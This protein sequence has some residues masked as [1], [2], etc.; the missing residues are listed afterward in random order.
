[1]RLRSAIFAVLLFFPA[2][3]GAQLSENDNGTQGMPGMN[4]G[5]MQGMQMGGDGL[6]TMHPES[7]LQ[8]IVRHGTSG[9]SAEP[10]STPV[11]M[12]MT[13]KGV[14]MLMFHANAF[15]IDEQQS[16]PRGGNKFFSTNWFMGMAQRPLGPGVF[17]A[18]AMSSL[19]PATVTQRRYPLLFQQG[20]TAFG[21]PIVDGQ[22]PHDFVME[23][24]A[25]YD[26]RL[27]SRGLLSF[28]F[29]PIGDPAM[30]PVA[31]PHRASASEDP[32]AALGHHQ[33]DSTHIADDVITVGLAYRIARIEA[34][35]FHGREPDENRWNI[36]QG[37][38]DSWSTRLALQPGKNWSGQFSY[39]RIK[40]PEAFFPNE[41]QGRMTASVQYNHPLHDGNWTSTILWGRTRS[42]QD[43]SIF[44]SYALESTVRFRVRNYA[45]TRIEN[46]DRSN[47]LILGENPLPPNFQEQPI[48]RV[49]A[50]TFG[51]DR[52]I[53]LIPHVASALG[54]QVTAYGVGEKLKPAYGS[55]PAGIAV[56][57][58][59]RPFS[60]DEK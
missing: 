28:Y 9:T 29:A 55:R 22:H 31:Y 13:A 51:Y 42:L 35:G 33:E 19:E 6:I 37:K 18:R 32:L 47:E 1:M 52:D 23:I 46:A 36:D 59:I 15:V 17:T 41:D 3:A 34:S 8:E 40:S 10:N 26:L 4:G 39:A 49:Q 5:R 43:G 60:G 45:W 58:R 44:N 56:F 20:E 14:W 25:L 48:G 57:V 38:I 24:A 11:P 54:V 50:Y 2:P 12:L 7:F 21:K 53:D 16:S 27:G 30:G